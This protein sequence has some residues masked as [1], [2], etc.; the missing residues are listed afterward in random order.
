MPLLGAGTVADMN[1]STE[2]RSDGPAFLCAIR[3]VGSAAVAS[4]EEADVRYKIQYWPRG[5]FAVVTIVAATVVLAL[6]LI[7]ISL[8]TSSGRPGYVISRIWAWVCSRALGVAASLHGAE[9]VAPGTSYVVTPNHQS[10]AD[11]LALLRMLPT[12]Y[13]W[14]I[15]RELVKIPVFG[16]GLARTGAVS[17]D[18]S[19][20]AQAVERLRKS[21]DKLKGGWSLLIYPEGTRTR[22]GNVQPFKKGA[23]MLAVNTGIPILPVT[24]NG[25]FKMLPKSAYLP[26]PGHV[27]IT[28]G[29][30]IPTEG[31]TQADVP[32][33]M[34]RTRQAV[35]K[36]FDPDFDPFDGTAH[37][38]LTA[39]GKTELPADART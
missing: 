3:I 23:F 7:L 10:N 22:D 2:N 31:L 27:A 12:P 19:N 20:T 28:I 34:E 26:I 38:A 36:H 5:L 30:P 9:K 1:R 17:I 25:A 35:L 32:E 33:L 21:V 18:R 8:F 6:T 39:Q 13:R 11:I 14:V 16:W 24:V 4:R 29:D 15:K 37:A